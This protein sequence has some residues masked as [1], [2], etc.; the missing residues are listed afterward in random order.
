MIALSAATVLLI[1]GCD[2][3]DGG[4]GGPSTATV[5]ST[6]DGTV[7]PSDPPPATGVGSG[8]ATAEPAP[9]GAVPVSHPASGGA[10]LSVTGVR[11]G[12]HDAFDRVVFDLGGKGSP[13]WR[14][15][16]TDAPAQ[17]GSGKPIT[18][19]GD[20][21]LQV[22]LTGLGYPM[23]TGVEEYSGPNPITGVHNVPQVHL[24]GVF[25][26]E[27]VGFIGVNADKPAIRVTTLTN[28]TR[29]VVDIAHT[30]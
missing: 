1:A 2:S 23:D 21:V 19:S 26:G 13:G 27:A 14:V 11:V 30:G 8:T 16:Y 9:T 12:H 24:T 10:R 17:P 5:T 7:T 6:Q 15:D 29:L 3:D 25:E 20:S 22:V 18:V 28:P 4:T